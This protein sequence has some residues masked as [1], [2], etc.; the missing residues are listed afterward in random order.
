MIIEKT[1]NRKKFVNKSLKRIEDLFK[2][3]KKVLVKPNIVSYEPYPTTTHPEVLRAVL[4]F[5]SQFNLKIFVADGP[6]ATA[7][8]L[9]KII[10]EHPLN[11]VCKEF[12]LSLIDILNYPM[13]SIRT[14][15]GYK[16]TLSKLPFET[17]LHISLPVLKSHFITNI[18]GAL[19]NQFGLLSFQERLKLHSDLKHILRELKSFINPKT[20]V[21]K[22]RFL[23]SL[24]RIKFRFE[25]KDIHRGIAELNTII[26]PD[27]FII[28]A[29]ETFI[30][31]QEIRHG[32]K[33][34]KLGYMLSGKDPLKLD[35]K[36]FELLKNIDPNLKQKKPEDIEY[37]KYA[38]E[39]LKR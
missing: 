30:Y 15:T 10:E 13:V 27:L 4:E 14:K 35:I 38:K 26:K 32:G 19:K 2:P 8:T 37:I 34:V 12:G 25:L 33:P 3:N 21:S 6:A 18:T 7:G 11:E 20:Y 29:I 24:E 16:L 1:N 22:S 31:A 28:D 23:M 36:G 39:L 17:D 5:L 9:K